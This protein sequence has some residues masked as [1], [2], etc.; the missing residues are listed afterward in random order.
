[1]NTL[2]TAFLMG[3]LM[4]L[5]LIIGFAIGGRTGMTIAFIIGLGTN[6]FGYWF[7]DKMVLRAYNAQPVT[8]TEAPE[9]W[10]MVANLAE[11]AQ[12]PMP[13]VYLLPSNQPNA[14]ATGR[15]PDHA[16]VAVTQGIMQMLDRDELEGVIAHELAHIKHYDILTGTLAATIAGAITYI[17]QMARWIPFGYSG[18]SRDN[19]PNPIFIVIMSMTA[20]FAAM[21]IQMA[22]SRSR[23]FEAD[24]GGAKIC[25]NPLA[26]AK[27]LEKLEMGARS[28]PM[29]ASP[30]SAHLFQIS[31][32][33]GGNGFANL[34]ST[35]PSTAERIRRLEAMA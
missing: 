25:N 31:P 11:R 27:A 5:F 32:F 21:L 17:A 35:H 9:L 22:I 4:A 28:I 26:L 8:E 15:N 29:N 16:A 12:L 19:R 24:A 18:N 3:L 10:S 23:E 1:M 13:K 20:P 14:F 2:R 33:G 7:S 30:T 6:F 34:F